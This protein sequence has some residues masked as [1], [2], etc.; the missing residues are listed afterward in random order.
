[1]EKSLLNVE[2]I[3]ENSGEVLG[4]KLSEFLGARFKQQIF[5][6]GCRI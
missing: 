1:M 5:L 3:N 2:R 4:S 6:S